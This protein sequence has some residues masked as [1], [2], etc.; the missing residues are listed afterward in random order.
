MIYYSHVNEDN[1]VERQLL[2]QEN[3]PTVIAIAGS[4]ER[5]L[6]LMDIDCTK[7]IIIIDSNIE[8]LFLLQLKIAAITQLTTKEYLKFIGHHYNQKDIRINNFEKIKNE[9]TSDCRLYWEKNRSIIGNGILNAGHFEHFLNKVRPILNLFLGRKFSLL[10]K[11][12][13]YQLKYLPNFRWKLITYFFSQ[14]WMYKLFGNRD[15][16]FIGTDARNKSI[17]EAITKIIEEGKA[18]SSFI[19]HLIFKGSLQEMKEEQ[20]PPSLQKKVINAIRKRIVNKGINIEYWHSDLLELVKNNPKELETPIFYSVSDILSFESFQYLD[21]LIDCCT[22]EKS[23][24]IIFR[25]FLRNQLTKKELTI[26]SKQNMIIKQLDEKESTKMYQV[27]SMK[28]A[29]K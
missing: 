1:R 2:Q 14:K 9:L 13:N 26:L 17:P 3:C 22:K 11:N 5:V 10:F 29:T 18:N 20:L 24:I 8:A 23:N 16:A 4:G 15:L 12:E 27:F 6:A 19:M 28:N 21:E 25:S 7:K